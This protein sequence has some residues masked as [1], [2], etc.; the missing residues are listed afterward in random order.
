MINYVVLS[1]FTDQGIRN[2][3]DTV[4][5]TEAFKEMAKKFGVTVKES[6]WTQ[7]QYDI[8]TIVEA[9][10]ELSGTALNMNLGALGN[11]R[12]QTLRAFVAD[13]MKQIIAKMA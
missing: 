13:E 5:R 4:K 3:K 10:D 12:T 6:F 2:A 11:I 7:G 8:V 9:Q 1:T